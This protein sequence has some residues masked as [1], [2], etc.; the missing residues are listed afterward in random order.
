M[1]TALLTERY[2]DEIQ[3]MLHCYDRVIITGSLQPICY[4]KGMTKYL[5]THRIRIFDYG[6]QFAEP[7]KESI[8]AIAEAIAKENG[9]GIEFI[10][11]RKA[12]RK[13]D[14]IQKILNERGIHPGL[15]HIFSAMEGC[16]AYYPWRDP[17]TG[18]SH[19]RST[20]KRCLHYYFY[21]IDAELGLCYLR[22]PT[23]CPFRLQF[24]VNG[25]NALAASLDQE[26]VDYELADN[27]FLAIADFAKANQ[28]AAELDVEMLHAK[29]DSYA[30]RYC[31]VPD[32]LGLEYSWSIMQAEYATD[33]VFRSKSTVEA[34][35]PHLVESLI[36]AVKPADIAT[37]LGRKL[38]G[39]YQDEMG[40]RS[41]SSCMTNSTSSCALRRQSM[42]S[43][44]SST[45][46]MSII[47]MARPRLS[48]RR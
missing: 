28:L 33:V 17:E 45:I 24:Y 15:V 47:E 42:T 12:F 11:K 41:P 46:D 30:S 6:K 39:N 8:R 2:G 21:F 32:A 23:Y 48:M 1:A 3:G 35:F 20:Q 22:V 13:E 36:Q 44:S 25:H 16:Q 10:R 27:A 43:L 18:H 31:A 26:A 40:N 19:V 7:L 37:F 29:L 4:A 14:R 9:L 5:Y 38:H 34:M